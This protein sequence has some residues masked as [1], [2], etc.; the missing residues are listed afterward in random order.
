MSSKTF[1]LTSIPEN[2]IL[3]DCG[4]HFV[5]DLAFSQINFLSSS[6]LFSVRKCLLD[7]LASLF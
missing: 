6:L 3:I 5:F 1:L 2:C 7:I 4:F